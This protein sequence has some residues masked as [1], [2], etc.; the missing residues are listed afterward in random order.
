VG[1]DSAYY[2]DAERLYLDGSLYP[3]SGLHVQL[4]FLRT[5]ATKN[6]KVV[7]LTHHNGLS[8]DGS[9]TTNLWSQVMSAFPAGTGPAYWYWGH[10]HAGVVYKPQGPE[11]I[12]CRCNGHGGVPWG[13]ASEFN[14]PRVMWYEKRLANDPDVPKRVLNGFVVISLDGPNL[15]ELF[16]DENAG[17]A[18]S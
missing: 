5:Q 10:V 16:Y 12:L 2:A 11:N 9:K 17:V 6:K 14:N 8:E 13:Q 1:L 7:V 15:T 4:D 3:A 18:W